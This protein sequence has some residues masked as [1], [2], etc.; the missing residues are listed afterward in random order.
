MKEQ[1]NEI[2]IMQSS[3]YCFVYQNKLPNASCALLI[4]A[5]PHDV[6]SFWYRSWA[7]FD[8]DSRAANLC[9]LVQ[10]CFCETAF[11]ASGQMSEQMGV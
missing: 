1:R 6:Q 11:S 8:L 3:K 10:L 4:P 2:E 7:N 9:S 5:K